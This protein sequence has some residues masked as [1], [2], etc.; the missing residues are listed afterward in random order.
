[1]D[2]KN[3]V[4]MCW[5]DWRGKHQSRDVNQLIDIREFLGTPGYS[6][7][8]VAANKHL[9]APDIQAFLGMVSRES[10][11]TKWVNRPQTWIKQRRWTFQK[12]GTD[13]TK[14]PTSDPDGKQNQAVRLMNS[15]PHLSTRALVAL[16]KERGILRS[17]EW[18][19]KHRCDDV[20]DNS[21]A[22]VKGQH[23]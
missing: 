21:P 23:Q 14:R 13:N 10:E 11:E 4:K 15:N 7:L 18:V 22:Y 17:R 20:T 16:L 19:R 12:P 1:M 6:I 8:V 2:D 5:T 9:S 3:C